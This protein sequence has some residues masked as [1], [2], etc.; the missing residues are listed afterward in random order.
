MWIASLFVCVNGSAQLIFQEDFNYPDGPLLTAPN[1]PWESDRTPSNQVDVVSGELFL[2]QTEQ[3]SVRYELPAT[4]AEGSR[5]ASFNLRVTALPNGNGN[6][7]AYFR[8]SASAYLGRVWITNGTVE[9]TYRLGVVTINESAVL[10]PVDLSIGDTHTVVLR[11]VVDQGLYT[12]TLWVDPVSETDMERR[13]DH[14]YYIGPGY[15]HAYF[16][17]K[18]VSPGLDNPANGMGELF[19]DNLRIGHVFNDVMPLRF[20]SLTRLDNGGVHLLGAGTAGTTYDVLVTTDLSS[21]DWL[22]IGSATADSNGVIDFI[23]AGAVDRPVSFYRLAP[24]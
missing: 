19:L 13:A 16:G 12:S 2:T 21:T 7:F 24:Q 14:S 17:F 18:Q 23:D 1:S 22:T 8:A 10:I 15:V 6:W 3:E 11:L 20:T 4:F 5:T 9:G